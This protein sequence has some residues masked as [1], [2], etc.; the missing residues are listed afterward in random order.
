MQTRGKKDLKDIECF[1]CRKKGH[2]ASNCPEQKVLFSMERR[3]DHKG[4]SILKK[5][6]VLSNPSVSKAGLVEGKPVSSILLDTGCSRTLVR[7]DLVPQHKLLHGEAVAIRCAHGDTVLYPLAEVDL[8]IDGYPLHVEAAISD[9]LPMPVL[10]GTDV[11]ELKAL[12]TGDLKPP[13]Q[14]TDE[15]LV[16]TTRAMAKKQ[17]EEGAIQAQKEKESGAQP[18]VLMETQK[19]DGD[20]RF[21]RAAHASGDQTNVSNLE[22]T[23]TL[24]QADIGEDDSTNGWWQTLDEELFGESRN[25]KHLTRKQKREQRSKHQQRQK[26]SQPQSHLNVRVPRPPTERPDSTTNQTSSGRPSI[27]SRDWILS[28]RWLTIPEVD[29]AKTRDRRSRSG[30]VGSSKGVS[31]GST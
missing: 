31:R 4:Q 2:Y 9:T 3:I 29:T 13:T 25:K 8:E 7:K 27:H 6:Q 22:Q 23:E 10:L 19:Q 5:T 28:E 11:P 12:L 15:A 24:T 26:D 20:G 17:E 14:Q 21:P 30:A 1:N 16:V 18:H